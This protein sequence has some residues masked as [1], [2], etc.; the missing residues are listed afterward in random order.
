MS[1]TGS[2]TD[3]GSKTMTKTAAAL[4]AFAFTT[5]ATS[6]FVSGQVVRFSDSRRRRRYVVTSVQNFGGVE[7][8]NMVALSGA[9]RGCAPSA[10]KVSELTLDADQSVEFTGASAAYLRNRYGS[11]VAL[12]R[13]R[14]ERENR[15]HAA[16]LAAGEEPDYDV[17]RRRAAIASKMISDELRLA[18]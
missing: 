8:V 5:I 12:D 9:V 13:C 7:T 11:A 17:M 1:W 6:A 10:V 16:A 4:A 15:A 18:N 3:T 14:E 2:N